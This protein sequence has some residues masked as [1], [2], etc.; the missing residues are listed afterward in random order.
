LNSSQI[1]IAKSVQIK[2]DAAAEDF[3]GQMQKCA[4]L[5]KTFVIFILA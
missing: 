4:T 1:Q 5:T 2:S 3:D